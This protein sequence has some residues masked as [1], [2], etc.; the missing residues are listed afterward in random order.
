MV[1]TAQM[2]WPILSAPAARHEAADACLEAIT[3]PASTS[4]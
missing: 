1:G 4:T 3:T 2:R